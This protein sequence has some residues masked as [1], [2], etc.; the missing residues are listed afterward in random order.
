MGSCSPCPPWPLKQRR[1]RASGSSCQIL[2][3][4]TREQLPD[5]CQQEFRDLPLPCAAGPSK[6]LI[7]CRDNK[8]RSVI[9]FPLL[10]PPTACASQGLILCLWLW[11]PLEQLSWELGQVLLGLCCGAPSLSAWLHCLSCCQLSGPMPAEGTG[12]LRSRGHIPSW[13]LSNLPLKRRASLK[14]GLSCCHCESLCI[15]AHRAGSN[16]LQRW[17]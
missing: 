1:M 13:L 10:L 7:Q 4:P 8:T 16:P 14:A 5:S 12:H 3:Q 15:A 6:E 11:L 9:F 17:E 2:Q